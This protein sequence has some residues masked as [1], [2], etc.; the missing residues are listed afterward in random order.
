MIV[1]YSSTDRNAVQGL[2]DLTQQGVAVDEAMKRTPGLVQKESTLKPEEVGD[3]RYRELV[4]GLPAGRL[5]TV[6]IQL[7]EGAASSSASR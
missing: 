5:H 4:F 1:E 2:I 7:S 6:P 3:E